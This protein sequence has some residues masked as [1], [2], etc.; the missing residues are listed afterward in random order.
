MEIADK[1]FTDWPD[2]VTD[3]EMLA[4]QMPKL[5]TTLKTSTKI[6]DST[7]T[8]CELQCAALERELELKRTEIAHFEKHKQEVEKLQTVIAIWEN[9]FRQALRELRA[10]VVPPQDTA[11]ILRHLN[12]KLA[13]ADLD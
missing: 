7:P 8:T 13:L 6:H 11:T 2:D 4:I 1:L 12:I 10:N 3:T 5:P 9:G